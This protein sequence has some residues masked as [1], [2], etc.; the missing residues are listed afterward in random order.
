[1]LID[2]KFEDIN[3]RKYRLYT[4]RKLANTFSPFDK[5]R[6]MFILSNADRIAMTREQAWEYLRTH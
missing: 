1:M 2:E 3:G 5:Y 6:N 4:V